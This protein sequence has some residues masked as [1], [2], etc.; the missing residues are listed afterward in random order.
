MKSEWTPKK[1]AMNSIR[2]GLNIA[3]FG[4]HSAVPEHE[5]GFMLY[6]MSDALE[7]DHE[8]FND[9]EVKEGFQEMVSKLSPT[10]EK[11]AQDEEWGWWFLSGALGPGKE[12]F[13]NR[14]KH[15][16]WWWEEK[17]MSPERLKRWHDYL[18]EHGYNS[19]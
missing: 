14:E 5:V 10:I 15:W 6:E 12:L 18:K 2:I 4:L 1:K 9:N 7:M 3:E 17:F 16:W 8:L 11:H 19:L 13:P